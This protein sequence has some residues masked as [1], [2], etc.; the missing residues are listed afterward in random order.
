MTA[1]RCVFADGPVAGQTILVTGGAGAV[2]HYAIQLARWGGAKVI[3]T[4]SGADKAAHAKAAGADYIVNYKTD[5]V[6]QSGEGH[7]Q[8]PGRRPRDRGGVRRQPCH[9]PRLPQDQRRDRDLCVV[10]RD[11]TEAAVLSHDV[12]GHHAADGAGLHPARGGAPAIDRGHQ[13]GAGA[14]RPGACHRRRAIR[15]TGSSRRT[16]RSRAARRSATS[17][18]PSHDARDNLGRRSA[19][20]SAASRASG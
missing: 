7:H 6:A 13:P 10:R 3:A 14:G 18:S 17:W 15:W 20:R 12:P 8:G 2:G 11:G 16:R 5:D 9:H 4:V 1:H 19:A